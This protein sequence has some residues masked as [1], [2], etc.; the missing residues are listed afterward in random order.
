MVREQG[1]TVMFVTHDLEEALILGD[2]VVALRAHPTPQQPSLARV[3]DV[4]LPRPREQ[5]ATKE[6]PEFL[7]LRRELYGSLGH[8]GA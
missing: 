8:D 7:R 3:V 2:R 6:H 4:P 1:L 5:L